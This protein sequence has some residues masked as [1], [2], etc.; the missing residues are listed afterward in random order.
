MKPEVRKIHRIVKELKPIFEDCGSSAVFTEHKTGWTIKQPNSIYELE[1]TFDEYIKLV[2]RAI[3]CNDSIPVNDIRNIEKVQEIAKSLRGTEMFDNRWSTLFNT[4]LTTKDCYDDVVAYIRSNLDNLPITNV[5]IV[6]DWFRY[7]FM[8]NWFRVVRGSALHH[9]LYGKT[10][11][12]F[13][14]NLN[15]CHHS[16]ILGNINLTAEA[17]FPTAVLRQLK[18]DQIT[19]C[20]I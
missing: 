11:V 1:V 5:W 16:S 6:D 12:H 7:S 13:S 17:L 9:P 4:P 14:D 15:D 19:Q 18:L 2:P 8:G 20:L 3:S 10:M